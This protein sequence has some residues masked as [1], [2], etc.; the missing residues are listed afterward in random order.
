MKSSNENSRIINK[1]QRKLYALSHSGISTELL[2]FL[3]KLC[4]NNLDFVYNLI[5]TQGPRE[6]TLLT[7]TMQLEFDSKFKQA[8]EIMDEFIDTCEQYMNKSSEEIKNIENIP[9]LANQFFKLHSFYN[10]SEIKLENIN[11]DGAYNRILANSH[12]GDSINEHEQNYRELMNIVCGLCLIE[13]GQALADYQECL[14][15]KL[16]H[17]RR[18]IQACDIYLNKLPSSTI[19]RRQKN[20][21][22]DDDSTLYRFCE[23]INCFQYMLILKYLLRELCFS[24]IMLDKLQDDMEAVCVRNVQLSIADIQK[25]FNLWQIKRGCLLAVDHIDSLVNHLSLFLQIDPYTVI[26]SSIG[27]IKMDEVLDEKSSGTKDNKM[28]MAFSGLC[29][30]CLT[31]SIPKVNIFNPKIN[32]A[33]YRKQRYAFCSEYEYL[34]FSQDPEAITDKL[35]RL[36]Q[37]FPEL[38]AIDCPRKFQKAMKQNTI[39]SEYMKTKNNKTQTKATI[40]SADKSIDTNRSVATNTYH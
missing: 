17:C 19:T 6:I 27:L 5:H 26:C 28:N 15:L 33:F 30:V 32:C 40:T 14:N 36:T 23:A 7:I 39:L 22:S 16:L 8:H 11:A 25:V 35:R 13:S 2:D 20:L 21:G 4:E 24:R 9:K 37:I 12:I 34:E 29:C 18:R 38:V 1:D 31:S 3:L 10:C